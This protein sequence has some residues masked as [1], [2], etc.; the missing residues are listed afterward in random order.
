V[1]GRETPRHRVEDIA[2]DCIDAIRRHQPT[3]PYLLAG[4][5]SAGIVAFEIARQ[6]EA[7]NSKVGLLALID[8]FSPRAK[9][10]QSLTQVAAGLVRRLRLRLIQER[11]YHALLHRSSL[12]RWRRLEGIGEAQRWAHWSYRAQHYAGAA[13]LFVANASLDIV[14]EP[15]LG[16]GQLVRGGLNIRR[17]PG[18]HSSIMKAP[19]VIELAAAHQAELTGAT[20]EHNPALSEA[21]AF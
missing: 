10:K 13:C 8:S 5:S 12:S 9:R 4:Y 1:Y 2:A 21:V 11:A 19:L 14:R 7:A 3:G 15:T 17:L 16:W 6:L 20:E 18:G